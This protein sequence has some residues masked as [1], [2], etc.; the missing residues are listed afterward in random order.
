MEFTGQTVSLSYDGNVIAIGGPFDNLRRGSTWIYI[1]ENLKE[2]DNILA[3]VISE[4][5]ALRGR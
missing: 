4:P 2:P 1:P 5:K 3:G